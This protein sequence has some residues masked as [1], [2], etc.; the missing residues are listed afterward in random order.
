MVYNLEAEELCPA[1]VVSAST[2]LLAIGLALAL[3]ADT[4]TTGPN[5]QT[6]G[7]MAMLIGMTALVVVF[8]IRD[9]AD[10]G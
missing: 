9:P 4:P 5:L 8:S 10:R 2:A 3:G 7:L 6:L 1:V